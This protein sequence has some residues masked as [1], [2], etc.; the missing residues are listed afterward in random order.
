MK[1][2]LTCGIKRTDLIS[3]VA[4]A[5]DFIRG[6]SLRIS[7][8]LSVGVPGESRTAIR[9]ERTPRFH[10]FAI[11][12]VKHGKKFRFCKTLCFTCANG[13]NFTFCAIACGFSFIFII[14]KKLLQIAY[15]YVII[16]FDMLSKHGRK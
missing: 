16:Y 9:G 12:S 2:A 7:P 4:I 11:S 3:S 8:R 15:I 13:A 5:T 1:S 14:S 10:F 6:R